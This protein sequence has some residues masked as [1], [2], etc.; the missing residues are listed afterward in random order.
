V[1]VAVLLLTE[2]GVALVV[3]CLQPILQLLP[4]PQLQSRSAQALQR[5]GL[6]VILFSVRSRQLVVVGAD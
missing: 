6:E 5:V 1:G 3:F 4:V 2:A